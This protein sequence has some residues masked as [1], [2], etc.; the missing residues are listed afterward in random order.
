[1]GILPE[2]HHVIIPNT[3]C[4]FLLRVTA[5]V[6]PLSLGYRVLLRRP[7]VEFGYIGSPVCENELK[8]FLIL[9]VY[10]LDRG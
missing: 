4:A 1:M 8:L 3:G 10:H 9:I 6:D 7:I 2:V 5:F